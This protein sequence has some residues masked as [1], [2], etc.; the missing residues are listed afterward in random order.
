MAI[1]NNIVKLSEG[2]QACEVQ[3]LIIWVIML[4]MNCKDI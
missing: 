4:E 2:R 1:V 3:I